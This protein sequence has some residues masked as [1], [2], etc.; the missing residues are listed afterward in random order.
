[1]RG[2]PLQFSDPHRDAGQLCGVFIEFD[3]KYVVRT[4]HQIVL[5]VQPK[6]GGFQ[7]TL[8]LNVFQALE[9]KVQEVSAAA[10]RVQYPVVLQR[11]EPVVKNCLGFLE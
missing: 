3:A 5:P 2:A 4:G 6:C 10:C 7:M 1:M 9:A 8:E 11:F